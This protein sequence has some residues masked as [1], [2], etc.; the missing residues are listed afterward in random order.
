MRSVAWALAVLLAGI[1]APAAAQTVVVDLGA[2]KIA[3][4]SGFTGAEVLLFGT[5]EGDGDVVVVLRGPEKPLVVR[6]K[7][8]TAGMWLN[9]QE[10]IF[11]AAP[12]YYAVAATRPL[13]EIAEAA[14]WA[15]NRI[16]FRHLN[17]APSFADSDVDLATYREALLR[18]MARA[19]L[20]QGE[21]SEIRRVGKRLF[22]TTF[23]FPA[24]VPTGLF[25]AEVFLIEDGVMLSHR[26]TALE[27]SKS[28]FGAAMF[29]F[30]RQR[31]VLY[32]LV[33][34]M[35][36]LVAGWTA[37]VVFRKSKA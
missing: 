36:A 32:G 30:S 12:G 7:E 25:H 2:H 24:N 19:G 4:T 27:V 26:T 13:T 18:N 31:P 9:R 34:V 33:A 29:G 10:V 37:G 21:V 8:R 14:L 15:E 16:G 17:L 28:G 23:D 11:A 1:A 20:Y 35:V 3:I 22:R 6:R 5:H